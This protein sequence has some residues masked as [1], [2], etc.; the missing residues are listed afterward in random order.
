MLYLGANFT[1]NEQKLSILLCFLHENFA[2]NFFY[3]FLVG[4]CLQKMVFCVF[5]CQIFYKKL[6]F[7]AIF[8]VKFLQKIFFRKTF[9]N[10]FFSASFR[11]RFPANC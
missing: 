8:E 7:F 10:Q 11:K 2:S 3:K 5:L 9:V 4:K 1:I 6:Q